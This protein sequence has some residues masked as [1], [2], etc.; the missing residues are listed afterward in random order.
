MA[1]IQIKPL[2]FEHF[3]VTSDGEMLAFLVEDTTGKKTWIGL[4][5]KHAP[6][7]LTV[8]QNAAQRAQDKRLQLGKSDMAA[9]HT[10]E[11]FTGFLV[12][13]AEGGHSQHGNL[14]LLT[15]HCPN[16][17][18]FDFAVSGDITLENGKTLPE[19]IADILLDQ[20]RQAP[21]PRA[22]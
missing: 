1:D 11:K 18:R 10:N 3:D 21:R 12:H 13:A 20:S 15:L 7:V 17:L 22:H 19:A 4:D 16:G 2:K 5:W 6:T 9:D 14:Q 8:V